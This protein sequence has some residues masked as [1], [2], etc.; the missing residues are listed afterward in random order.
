[1]P[2]HTCPR[3]ENW[4]RFRSLSNRGFSFPFLPIGLL[5]A[6]IG[7]NS[8]PLLNSKPRAVGWP[9]IMPSIGSRKSLA[10]SGLVSG[11]AKMRSS[12]WISAMVCSASIRHNIHYKGGEVNRERS[13]QT[14][15]R[16]T[17]Y[18]VAMRSQ[19]PG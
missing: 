1:M 13:P 6:Q 2:K 4:D 12:H 8:V 14:F 11:A 18:S 15:L 16:E 9:F 7:S 3:P 17:N 5:E 19:P 10:L